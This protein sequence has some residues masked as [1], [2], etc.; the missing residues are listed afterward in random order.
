MQKRIDVDYLLMN[1]SRPFRRSSMNS[2][3]KIPSSR[4]RKAGICRF[5]ALPGNAGTTICRRRESTVIERDEKRL[6]LYY[7]VPILSVTIRNRN[8]DDGQNI[9][10]HERQADWS[11]R[12]SSEDQIDRT[13]VV[14]FHP[15]LIVGVTFTSE[16]MCLRIENFDFQEISGGIVAIFQGNLQRKTKDIEESNEEESSLT[17]RLGRRAISRRL[18]GVIVAM[19]E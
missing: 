18:S 13:S 10:S 12:A 17:G 2:S 6:L 15:D 1:C 16:A 8:I 19:D 4:R 9:L 3:S 7:R 11:R 5:H 14:Y